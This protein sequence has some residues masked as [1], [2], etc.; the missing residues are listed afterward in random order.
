MGSS[1]E[2]D[3]F[4]LLAF[5]TDNSSRLSAS[6]IWQRPYLLEHDEIHP[7]SSSTLNF[8]PG[9]RLLDCVRFAAFPEI[10]SWPVSQ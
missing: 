7:S 3:A 1:G 10:V 2:S 8:A 6:N 4:F 5:P 9:L